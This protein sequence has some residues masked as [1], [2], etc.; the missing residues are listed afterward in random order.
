MKSSQRKRDFL[1]NIKTDLL[2]LETSLRN[3]MAEEG[4]ETQTQE[5]QQDQEVSLKLMQMTMKNVEAQRQE[6]QEEET[7]EKA[8]KKGT[9][10]PP[11]QAG[12]NEDGY[13][14]SGL[15]SDNDLDLLV[16]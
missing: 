13:C 11:G 5:A 14:S 9:N 16:E 6:E 12:A 8:A 15:E 1:N 10:N 3:K 7:K 4:H 2:E